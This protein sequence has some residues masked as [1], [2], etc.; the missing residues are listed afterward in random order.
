LVHP[1]NIYV[2]LRSEKYFVEKN[3]PLNVDLIVTDLDGNPISNQLIEA[4][5]GR[6]VWKYQKGEWVEVF[7]DIQTC[8]INSKDEPVQCSFTTAI[9]GKYQIKAVVT[10]D[11]GRK[12]YSQI[13]RWVSGGELPPA[14]NVEQEQITLI[15]DKESYQ[16]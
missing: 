3:E 13:D 4:T 2:G 1:A 11:E 14:R 15:P 16:P 7:E 10:D 8:E 5:A 12:N 6:I 9:G